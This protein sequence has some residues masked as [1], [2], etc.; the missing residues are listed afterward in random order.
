[1]HLTL[2]EKHCSLRATFHANLRNSRSSCSICLKFSRL[3][4][5]GVENIFE[6]FR[7]KIQSTK[8]LLRG[9]QHLIG[10]YLFERMS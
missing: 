5:V 10:P 9:M 2:F 7:F 8:K 6:I 1:M 3:L 4:R